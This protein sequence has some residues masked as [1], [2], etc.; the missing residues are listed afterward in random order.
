MAGS[1]EI[2]HP[3]LSKPEAFGGFVLVPKAIPEGICVLFKIAPFYGARFERQVFGLEVHF[4]VTDPDISILQYAFLKPRDSFIDSLTVPVLVRPQI[5]F[6]VF[7]VP[8][9]AYTMVS[10]F[11]YNGREVTLDTL[12]VN[13]QAKSSG[14]SCVI[15]SAHPEISRPAGLPVRVYAPPYSRIRGDAN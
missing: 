7:C 11:R 1:Y 5:N 12:G 8:P 9:G 14:H 6:A 3:R 4:S 10:T 13:C 2:P 15:D